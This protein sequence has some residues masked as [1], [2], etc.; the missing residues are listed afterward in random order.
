M[1]AFQEGHPPFKGDS[2]Y[3]RPQPLRVESSPTRSKILP[4]HGAGAGSHMS[5]KPVQERRSQTATRA[6]C[7]QPPGGYKRSSTF[8]QT[9]G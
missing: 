9:S 6:R 5:C 3:L 4:P 7:M 2:P 1:V 8:A